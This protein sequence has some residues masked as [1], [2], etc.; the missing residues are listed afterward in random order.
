M[1]MASDDPTGPLAE[2]VGDWKLLTAVVECQ[3][4]GERFDLY[5][6]E[7]RGWLMLSAHGR[8]AA[9]ITS[10]GRSADDDPAQL[11]RT[12]LAYTATV[13][14]VEATQLEFS[15]DTAWQPSWVGTRQTRHVFV[16]DGVLVIRTGVQHHPNH[17]DRL[18]VGHLE[19]VRS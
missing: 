4:S 16:Q 8:V 9:I 1:T 14:M 11:L 3:T 12:M 10:A 18:L 2:L 15:I 17:G 7:P 13:R 19:W 5:G 6:P